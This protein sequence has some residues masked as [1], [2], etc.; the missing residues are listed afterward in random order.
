MMFVL[1]NAFHI[2]RLGGD[3]FIGSMADAL[4]GHG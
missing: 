4:G 2:D 3:D 1:E